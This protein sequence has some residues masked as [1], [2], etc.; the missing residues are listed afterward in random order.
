M[1]SHQEGESEVLET[2]HQLLASCTGQMLQEVEVCKHRSVVL[3][4]P[5]KL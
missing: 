2:I 3:Q 4:L 1:L 5:L